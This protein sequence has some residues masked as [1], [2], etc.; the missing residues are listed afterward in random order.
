MREYREY[1]IVEKNYSQHT[2]EAYQSDIKHF[3][4]FIIKT[5]QITD[6]EEI[7][8]DH[9]YA[10]LKKIRQN[11][12]AA[13]VDRH[14]ISLRQFYRF[15]IKERIISQNVMSP[16]DMPKRKKYLPQVLSEEEVNQL[17][18]SIEIHDAISS[19]NRCM[20]EI[21][22]A[23]GLRVSEMCQI[24][25]QNINIQ[26]RFVKCIGKG[27]KERI[28]PI[29]E[30]CCSLLKDY[31]EKYRNELC[32]NDS[33]PYLFLTQKGKQMKRDDFYHILQHIV[34]KSHLNKH[35]SPHTLR[36]TFATHLLEHDADLR[37]IQ[38]MLGHS[39]IS[40]TTIYTHVSQSKAI[41]DYRQLH[42]RMIERN[43]KNGK[44]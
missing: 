18:D 25:L 29:N 22:Y 15:L 14:M 36:H 39:D 11:L 20:V 43:K 40:T 17:L 41:E 3:I 12:S 44:I 37:S 16:F 23:C 42:P 31:I 13:A 21:L 4:D 1:M 10:Y 5:F 38:E 9:V 19:R 33:S 24:T 7:T 30:S 27:N 28:V 8:K 26:K 35:I 6:V 2:V 32:T 34:Q